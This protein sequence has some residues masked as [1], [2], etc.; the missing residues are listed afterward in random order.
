MVIHHFNRIIRT[1]WIWGAF[2]VTISV[3]FAFDFLFTGRD[4]EGRSKG[5]AGTLGDRDVSAAEVRALA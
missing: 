1:K 2:A 3:F 4:E 5:S